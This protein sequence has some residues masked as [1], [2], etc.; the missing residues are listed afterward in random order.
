MVREAPLIGL[1]WASSLP[2]VKRGAESEIRVGEFLGIR[3]V[4]KVRVPKAYMHPE[5]DRRLRAQRTLKE[6]KVMIAASRAGASVPRILAV[7]PSAGLI[8]MEF[9]DGPTLKD[10]VGADG[11]EELAV[12]AGRQ[13]ALI[14]G[15]GVVHGDYT[16]S[17]M[18]VSGGRLYVIDFG[19]SD[20]SSGVEDRAVDV[21]L[22]R[23]AVLSTHPSHAARFMELF[24]EGYSEVAGEA[25]AE[26]VARR[27]D[28]IELRGR[29]VAARSSVWGRVGLG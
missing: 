24:M 17:N 2:L 29:Y 6:A 13:L 10:L 3:A 7:H 16:T 20:F 23:R 14:H 21:H 15:A 19:L 22:L 8:V 28:E 9:I 26:R 12:E 27:A 4:F 25:E 11:W 1:E 5:L 18:I